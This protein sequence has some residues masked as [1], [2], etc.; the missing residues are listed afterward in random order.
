MTFPNFQA[1]PAELIF[2]YASH[3]NAAVVLL[4]CFFTHWAFL[5]D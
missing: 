2:A 4:D 3:V 5:G 1:Y